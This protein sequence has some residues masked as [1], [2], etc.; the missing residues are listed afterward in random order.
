VRGR[1]CMNLA[2]VDV[3]DIAGV[4]LE[5]PVTLIGSHGKD[6][7]SAEQLAA[8]AGTINYEILARLSPY[9]ERLITDN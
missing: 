4:K 6:L 8:W 1:V 3:T 5:D 9:I 7:I 2:M